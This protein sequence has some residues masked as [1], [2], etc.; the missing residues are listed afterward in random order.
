M[1]AKKILLS[2]L[3]TICFGFSALTIT[4]C[5]EHIHEWDSGKIV[6]KATCTDNGLK[7]YTCITC[8]DTKFEVISF[9]GHVEVKDLAV[10][11]TCTST[12]LTE[13][14]HCSVCNEILIKQE[15]I[16]TTE[17][18]YVNNVCSMCNEH[19]YT[20]G[21]EFSLS[22]D[23]NSYS[24]TDYVGT[25]T[26][27]V[28]P[29]QYKG[30]PV[31]CIAKYA[32]R[33]CDSLERTKIPDSITTI[34]EYAFEDC[35]SLKRIIISNNVTSIGKGAFKGCVLLESIKIPDS[36]TNIDEDAFY[37]CSSLTSVT[38]GNKVEIIGKGAF[39]GCSSLKSVTI[40]SS[41]TFIDAA[42][43]G[44]CSLLTTV[45]Y[46]GTKEQWKNIY[47]DIQGNLNSLLTNATIVYNYKG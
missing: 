24:I 26:E 47:I 25:D 33:W 13:G 44:E 35:I 34:D 27:I 38:I 17:H 19:Y 1:K 32:F 7:E 42:A 5:G 31:K 16:E 37:G 46:T 12:G 23:G 14:S 11:A 4:S 28:L 43:F 30:K 22:E 41:V 20:K 18:N 3:T 40:G 2:L 36:V 10:A 21:L 15:I 8:E 45:Y 6:D 9:L 29:S 39:Y